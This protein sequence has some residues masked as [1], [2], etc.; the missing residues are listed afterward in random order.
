M[1]FQS[2]AAATEHLVEATRI[3]MRIGGAPLET[4]GNVLATACVA[5][6]TMHPEWAAAY[7]NQ[8][9]PEI[10]ALAEAIVASSPVGAVATRA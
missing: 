2:S 10:R 3:A 8:I 6:A 9:S 7:A 4:A 5:A 1:S